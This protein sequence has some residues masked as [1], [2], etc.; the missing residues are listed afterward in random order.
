M[1]TVKQQLP[2]KASVFSQELYGYF[3]S[4]G[5]DGITLCQLGSKAHQ[6]VMSLLRQV[7]ANREG[8]RLVDLDVLGD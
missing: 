5:K 3:C 7:I 2:A 4:P 8:L 1:P 6:H